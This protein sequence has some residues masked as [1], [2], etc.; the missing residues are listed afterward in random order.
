[1]IVLP[2][3]YSYHGWLYRCIYNFYMS[4]QLFSTGRKLVMHGDNTWLKLFPGLFDRYDGV[5]SFFV[6]HVGYFYSRYVILEDE[7]IDDLSP[8]FVFLSLHHLLL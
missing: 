1:M 2:H 7:I 3:Y 4:D 5:N 8:D 6:S